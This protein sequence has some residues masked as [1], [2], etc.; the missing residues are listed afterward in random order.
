MRINMSA[1][2]AQRVLNRGVAAEELLANP[3]FV[4][5]IDD[6][7][8]MHLSALVSAP[9]GAAALE[10][11]EYHHTM[12]SALKEIVSDIQGH[13]SAANE[14]RIRLDLDNSE[15]DDGDFV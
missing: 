4:R 1:E 3:A 7:S 11:R 8:M 6:L 2:E 5:V 14:I 13:V 15:D 12:H 10:A 9:P